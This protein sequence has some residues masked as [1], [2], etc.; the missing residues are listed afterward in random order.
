MTPGMERF[1]NGG[2]VVGTTCAK[3]K[4]AESVSLE[5]RKK[6]PIKLQQ[7]KKISMRCVHKTKIYY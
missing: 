5:A 3:Q 4:N 2:K 1:K 6:N 7:N